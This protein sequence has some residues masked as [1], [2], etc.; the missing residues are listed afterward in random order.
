MYASRVP[1]PCDDWIAAPDTGRLV[2][3]V[4]PVMIGF[5]SPSVAIAENPV[6]PSA[7]SMP[8]PPKYVPQSR[9]PVL[10]NR[11]TNASKLPER[12]VWNAPPV[13]GKLVLLVQPVILILSLMSVATP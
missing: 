9:A 11:T 10:L 3:L 1:P 12:V 5:P 4:T 2:L 8:E 6:I 7:F 13:T